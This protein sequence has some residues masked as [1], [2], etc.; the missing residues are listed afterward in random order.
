[1]YIKN[2]NNNNITK[3]NNRDYNKKELTRLPPAVIKFLCCNY[4]FR[5]ERRQTDRIIFRGNWKTPSRGVA[6][7]DTSLRCRRVLEIL[8]NYNLTDE[9]C[10]GEN[11]KTFDSGS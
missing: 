10:Y 8:G 11:H 4:P 2:N 1:M 3:K 5:H 9:G 7:N 6:C